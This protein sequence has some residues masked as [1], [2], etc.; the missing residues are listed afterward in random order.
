MHVGAD[1]IEL[2]IKKKK[3]KLRSKIRRAMSHARAK[4]NVFFLVPALDWL[5]SVDSLGFVLQMAV[6]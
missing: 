4:Y 5:D 1:Q 2:G 6:S 3:K